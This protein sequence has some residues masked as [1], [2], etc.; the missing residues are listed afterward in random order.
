M[1]SRPDAAIYGCAGPRLNKDE[2][3]FLAD[4]DPL[5]IILFARNCET[6]AQ[7][8]A[9]IADISDCLGYRPL[10][11]IDQ[12][13]GRVARL[14]PPHWP[15]L[16]A[17][18]WIG[19]LW[20]RDRV[21][22]ER[23]AYLHGRLLAAMLLPLDITV[24]CAPVLDIAFPETHDVIGDRAFSP[25]AKA[26][27]TLGRAL[28]DG[29]LDGGVLPVIKHVPGHGRACTDSHKE[30]PQV[31]TSANEL[32]IS[33]WLPFRA[34][35]DAPLAMTA[36]ILYTALDPVRP[37]TLSKTIIGDVIRGK[38]GVSG[39]L[40]SDDIGMK[41]LSGSPGEL[42][43]AAI[44]AGCDCVLHCSG[45]LDEMIAVAAAA[46]KLSDKAMERLQ[47]AIAMLHPPQP[48]DLMAFREEYDNLHA[49]LQ[50]LT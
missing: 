24:D 9:L 16:P 29:L 45:R 23:A 34:L 2:R 27:A 40:M 1:S 41:A 20:Q 44:A 33:D 35:A 36:H 38:L 11:L 18:A 17:V 14:R 8:R 21:A 39:L 22:A 48:A 31:D 5:G 25:N 10:I 32:A 7:I 12:E 6:P 47:R 46:G 13:G 4:A 19:D 37:A 26:V 30:L 50:Q 49:S 43:R 42:T 15:D 3:R 28:A